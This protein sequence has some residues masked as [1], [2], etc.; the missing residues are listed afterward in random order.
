MSGGVPF[1]MSV[2]EKCHYDDISVKIIGK[3]I[4]SASVSM[5]KFAQNKEH[6]IK[7]IVFL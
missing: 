5:S 7:R 2:Q 4:A 3:L 1:I 6:E